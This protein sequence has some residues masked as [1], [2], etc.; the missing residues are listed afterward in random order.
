MS[1]QQREAETSFR[2]FH[3]LSENIRKLDYIT[4]Q[5]YLLQ[6][7]LPDEGC[8]MKQQQAQNIAR[9]HAYAHVLKRLSKCVNGLKST[10]TDW[11]GYELERRSGRF[12]TMS[13]MKC[14]LIHYNII[15]SAHL[16]KRLLIRRL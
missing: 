2:P 10:T 7:M 11:Q 4:H 5:R 9:R 8:V 1:W 3:L 6:D 14:K 13:A 12:H 16:E 15:K